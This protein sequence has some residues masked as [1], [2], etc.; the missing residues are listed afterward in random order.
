METHDFDANQIDNIKQFFDLFLCMKRESDDSWIE[1]HESLPQGWKYKIS[2]GPLGGQSKILLP[3]GEMFLSRVKALLFIMKKGYDPEDIRKLRQ[4]LNKE[5]WLVSQYLPPEWL[6]KRCKTGRNEYNFLSPDGEILTSRKN[7]IDFMKRS[8]AYTNKDIDNIDMLTKEIKDQW[9]SIKHEWITDDPTILKGW[10]IR[11]F[12]HK[13]RGGSCNI[14]SPCGTLLHTR[15]SALQFLIKSPSANAE[16][17]DFMFDQLVHEGWNTH[18]KLPFHWRWRLK[19]KGKTADE[20]KLGIGNIFIGPDG[21]LLNSKSAVTFMENQREIYSEEDI[22]NVQKVVKE[23][24]KE[25]AAWDTDEHVPDGWSYKKQKHHNHVREYFRLPSG[26]ESAGR[27]STIQKLL[28]EGRQLKDPDIIILKSGLHLAGWSPATDLLPPGWFK[29]E[30]T[31]T[32]GQYKYV[33]PEFKEFS[34]LTFVYHYIKANGYSSEILNLVK[35]NL[36]IKSLFKNLRAD[37]K[38]K[39]KYN[40]RTVDYLPPNWKIAEKM[41]KYQISRSIYLSPSGILLQYSVLA[42]QVMVADEVDQEYLDKMNEKLLEDGW[43]GEIYLT[44]F[45]IIIL[46]FL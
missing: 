17:I 3:S 27:I 2:F 7:L 11:Y 16:D 14:L 1:D 35:K 25:A 39:S 18:P 26:K 21:S 6:F 32:P 23:I 28:K 15:V 5:G 42:Y 38:I 40:W 13:R 44:V 8:D 24:R 12:D 31:K 30:I 45:I 36:K 20:P 9:V 43:Q 34:S 19:A 10:S 37:E 22:K 4:S 46:I 29:K 41:F 33:S